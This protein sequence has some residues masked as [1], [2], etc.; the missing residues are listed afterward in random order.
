M[1]NIVD[2]VMNLKKRNI[3]LAA[4]EEFKKD[5]SSEINLN[6][7]IRN[8]KMSKKTFYNYFQNKAEFVL[9]IENIL[10]EKFL[11]NEVL[12][13][14]GSNG[15]EKFNEFL[16]IKVK[17]FLDNHEI[18]LFGFNHLSYMKDSEAFFI[19]GS[20]YQIMRENTFA[21][22]YRYYEEGIL[23][24][25]IK[26]TLGVNPDI[27]FQSLVGME[28]YYALAKQENLELLSRYRDN[29]YNYIK[30]IEKVLKK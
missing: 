30:F 28:Y 3:A 5:M 21:K 12:K 4:L 23:D 18:I 10:Y 17:I 26:E 22:A 24:G 11:L 9:L 15:Y 1:K 8:M 2:S 25:S 27:I 7:F 6:R 20:I 14:S 19:E 13:I 29:V 16:K